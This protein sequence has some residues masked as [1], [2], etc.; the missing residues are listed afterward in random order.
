MRHCDPYRCD[1]TTTGE[2][3]KLRV[4][5]F[6]VSLDG[7][8]AGPE[9]GPA[10]PLGRGGSRL[11]AWVFETVLGRAMLGEPG[12]VPGVDNDYLAAG[13]DG[14]G[15][16]IMGRNMFGPIRGAWGEVPWRGWWGD[17][18]P[19]HHPVFVLT[20]H[21]HDPIAMDGG[22]TFTF[23]T[24]GIR[25]ALAAAIEA[26]DGED[27][28]LGWG[29]ATVRQYLDAG[30]IDELHMVVVPTL[31]GDGEQLLGRVDAIAAGYA[32][33]GYRSSTNVLHVHLARRAS[34]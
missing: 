28:R 27:V 18:P 15:A 21:P 25:A 14:I 7:Y 20:H 10:D 5:N 32:C 26:A 3:A 6:A 33:V 24:D 31:L 17:D 34:V 11:H 4:H 8:G 23:V 9:Q 22:T 19:Y 16:T 1:V 29:V 30:L 2:R 12:G 13:E